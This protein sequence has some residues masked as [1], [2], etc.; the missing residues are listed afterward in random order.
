VEESHAAGEGLTVAD[1]LAASDG[2]ALPHPDAEADETPLIDGVSAGEALEEVESDAEREVVAETVTHIV[3]LV[4]A[5]RLGDG[6]CD[7]VP[8][9]VSDDDADELVD[10]DAGADPLPL[11][12]A[13]IDGDVEVERQPETDAETVVEGHCEPEDVAV[14][15]CVGVE[16][17]DSEALPVARA[18]KETAD[19]EA[20]VESD[21]ELL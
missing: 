17:G 7:A 13:D 6:V 18:E 15:G 11:P 1:A 2:E 5:D 10:G 14:T 8:H 20:D 16:A 4:D 12:A 19:A 21:G 9:A 3:A